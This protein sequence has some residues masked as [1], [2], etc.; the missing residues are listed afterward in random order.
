[1]LRPPQDTLGLGIPI[2]DVAISIQGDDGIKRLLDDK[3]G[4]RIALVQG[5]QS[6]FMLAITGVL[7]IY[8]WHG[9]ELIFCAALYSTRS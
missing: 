4:T 7:G 9:G 6:F 3:A 5:Y 2:G 8:F 1:M